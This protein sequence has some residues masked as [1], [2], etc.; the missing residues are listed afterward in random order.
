MNEQNK[1]EKKIEVKD[2]TQKQIRA[3]TEEKKGKIA[4]IWKKMVAVWQSLTKEKKFYLMTATGCAVAL[5][6]I[7]VIAIAVSNANSV[8]KQAGLPK[9]ST[10]AVDSGNG[11]QNVG[12]D[13]V[14][15]EKEN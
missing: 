11:N 7:V 8:D 15:D 3:N 5:L 2:A 6:A 4:S 10:V 14:E 1:R 9:D 13:I 12:G